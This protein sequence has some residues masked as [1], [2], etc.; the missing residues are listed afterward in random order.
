MRHRTDTRTGKRTRETV[1][2]ITDLTSCDAA[3]ERLAPIARSQQT[4]E[5][6]PHSL[7]DTTSA[8]DASKIRTGH[9]PANAA[10]LHDLTI[11]LLRAAEHTNIAAAIGDVS[12]QPFPRP[13]DL[14][15]IP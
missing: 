6:R 3:P 15:N 1:Y 10:T 7:R 14:L 8:E 5:N 13:L 4:V 12:Y 9:G 2:A 11:N